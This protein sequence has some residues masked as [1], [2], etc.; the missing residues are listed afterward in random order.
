MLDVAVPAALVAVMN[1]LVAPTGTATL[2]VP[3]PLLVTGVASVPLKRMVQPT[4]LAP[5]IVTTVPKV[6]LVGVNDVICGCL[7][8]MKLKGLVPVPSAVV[9]TTRVSLVMLGTVATICVALELTTTAF[10][11]PKRTCVGLA[12][13]VPRIVTF[14]PGMPVPGWKP[15]ILGATLKIIAL[16]TV[17]LGVTT[18][19]GPV[20]APTGT[21]A[22][23]EVLDCTVKVADTP[24]N[25]TAVVPVKLAPMMKTCAPT[26]A[27]AG[28]KEVIRGEG[29]TV[30]LVALDT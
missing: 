6:P 14:C 7:A 3:S 15:V 8:S 16:V 10:N 27:D 19:T 2:T 23:M 29:S 20:V 11:V 1:P 26:G 25:L 13:E 5:E 21:V 30:K 28:E 17:A 12:S 4:R 9:T 18:V 22:M 24:L